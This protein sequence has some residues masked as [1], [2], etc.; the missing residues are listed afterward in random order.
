MENGSTI[1]EHRFPNGVVLLAEPMPWLQSAA[2]SILLPAGCQFD[3]ADRLGLANLTC[4]MIQRGCGSRDNRQFIEDLEY[5]GADYGVSVSVYHTA[6]AGT[7]PA[8]Q[9]RETLGIFADV[10]CRPHLPEE[11]LDDGKM[12]CIQEIRSLEDD[13]AHKAMLALRLRYYGDPLGRA[14][15][16]TLDG[17]ETATI[18]DVREFWRRHSRSGQTIISVAGN[19]SWP[20]LRDEVGRLF[21]EMTPGEPAL[22]SAASP[23]HGSE[24]IS[25]ESQQTHICLAFPS[26]AYRDADYFRAR[27][28][29]GV[30]S[31]G[32]SSRLFNE[33]RE[34]RGLCYSVF[35]TLHS[36]RDRACILCYAGTGAERAQETLDVIVDQFRKLREGISAE[37]LARLK[38]QIRSS[39]IMQQES[40]RSRASSI[41]GD[42]FHLGRVRSLDEVN[43]LVNALTIDDVND[44]V[45]RHLPLHCD[46]VTLGPRPLEVPNGVP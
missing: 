36:L 15:P 10:V 31:D 9:L 34:K 17:I 12:V 19:I 8:T 30:M 1:Y 11:Q 45:R 5:L 37:E 42:W 35:A 14:S 41:A 2:F 26:V 3:P 46:V 40:S 21:G 20:H 6:L 4:D 39:L 22:V 43:R 23:R 18:D 27:G 29:V 24:H 7:V 13:L 25:F 28:A 33:V 44:Y 38:V 32:M 16:G